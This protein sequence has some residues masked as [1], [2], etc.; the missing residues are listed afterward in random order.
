[1]RF[2]LKASRP[3]TTTATRS[4]AVPL[5]PRKLPLDVEHLAPRTESGKLSTISNPSATDAL[6]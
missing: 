6:C 2:G 1:M 3:H 4:I 5:R